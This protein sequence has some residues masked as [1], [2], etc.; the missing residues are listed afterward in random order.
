MIF[1]MYDR[2]H[3]VSPYVK[4]NRAR[5]SLVEI[6][7]QTAT[8]SQSVEALRTILTLAQS[9]VSQIENA[10]AA[11]D[12]LA[13]EALHAGGHES[14]SERVSRLTVLAMTKKEVK[15]FLAVHFPHLPRRGPS[16]QLKRKAI[17]EMK[18]DS[19]SE[20]TESETEA[21]E[22]KSLEEQ[23]KAKD[24]LA[25]EKSQDAKA[26]A[27]DA[28][29]FGKIVRATLTGPPEQQLDNDDM[30]AI[31]E[32]FESTPINVD[33]IEDQMI[34]GCRY[35]QDGGTVNQEGQGTTPGMWRALKVISHAVP[36]NDS[37]IMA[38]RLESRG[39]ELTDALRYYKKGALS[40][41]K[42]LTTS[43]V[44]QVLKSAGEMKKSKAAKTKTDVEE[45][46]ATAGGS[47]GHADPVGSSS[48][49]AAKTKT[50]VAVVST[51]TG[52]S[53]GHAESVGSQSTP[54]GDPWTLENV[55]EALQVK[56][57]VVKNDDGKLLNG[58]ARKT[59]LEGKRRRLA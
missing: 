6:R 5:D 50:D 25:E 4:A 10:T 55:D 15:D 42:P 40:I 49:D 35:G 31:Y 44:K 21:A 3:F 41:I 58:N 51:T 37:I 38:M 32:L 47:T 8:Q 27:R 19:W 39:V 54:R 9:K 16:S 52:G 30:K 23:M 59:F 57:I 1:V 12:A 33:D 14:E 20:A 45:V 48:L 13:L 18:G 17:A 11:V 34:I 29:A 46:S 22:K 26:A 7:Q 28:K 53:T 24:E 36:G 2:F 43:N 56:T